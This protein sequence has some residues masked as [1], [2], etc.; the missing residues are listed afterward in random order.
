MA[1]R[2]RLVV[3]R[4]HLQ[5]RR[6]LR[7]ARP[8]DILGRNLTIV[9]VAG[10]DARC[11]DSTLRLLAEHHETVPFH[12]AVTHTF[13]IDRADAAMQTALAAGDAMKVVI[14]P[15]SA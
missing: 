5:V 14:V 2:R 1:S 15:G 10:E 12:R 9:G 11:Y 6:A 4:R 7:T 3:R 8:A 13:S